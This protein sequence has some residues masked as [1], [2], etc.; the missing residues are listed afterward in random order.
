MSDTETKSEPSMEEILASIRRIITEEDAG[1]A[2]EREAE[3]ALEGAEDEEPVELTRMVDDSGE[4]VDLDAKAKEEKVSDKLAV[5]KADETKETIELVEKE[6]AG[7]AAVK[8]APK[9]GKAED[10]SLVSPSTKDAATASLAQVISA[11]AVPEKDSGPAGGQRSLEDVVRDALQPELRAWL[12]Q[13]LGPLVER[14]VREE[15]KKMV[16]RVEDR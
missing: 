14:I 1:D 5:A 10:G 7:K 4:V 11:V 3:E 12:D 8:D 15:I 6:G 2:P 9:A 16:R 13:N